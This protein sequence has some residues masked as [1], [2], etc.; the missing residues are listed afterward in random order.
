MKKYLAPEA[1]MIVLQSADCLTASF[2]NYS[3]Q[4]DILDFGEDW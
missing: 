4:Q 2:G 1:E 3:T